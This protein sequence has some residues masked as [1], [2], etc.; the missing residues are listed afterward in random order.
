MRAFREGNDRREGAGCGS[1][2]EGWSSRGCERA[3]SDQMPP[4]GFSWRKERD[5]DVHNAEEWLGSNGLPVRL[6]SETLSGRKV[7]KVMPR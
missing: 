3:T 2:C 6:S 4:K 7:S 1:A 5:W